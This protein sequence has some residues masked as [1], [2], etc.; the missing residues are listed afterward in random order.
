MPNSEDVKNA[1][2]KKITAGDDETKIY[3]R[4]RRPRPS[5][6]TCRGTSQA[7]RAPTATFR[8]ARS[9]AQVALHVVGRAGDDP[10][11]LQDRAVVACAVE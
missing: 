7:N 1:V 5:R 2:L 8:S 6:G 9:P 4:A 3:C 10:R 11:V